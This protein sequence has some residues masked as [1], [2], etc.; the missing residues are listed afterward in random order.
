MKFK[1]MG[2]TL[3]L[4]GAF[5]FLGCS[6]GGGGDTPDP[7]SA[8]FDNPDGSVTEDNAE[9]L[10][11]DAIDSQAG[12]ESVGSAIGGFLRLNPRVNEEIAKRFGASAPKLD[13]DS[14][15]AQ[16][17]F[18]D[19]VSG[20]EN[21][22]T[23]DLGCIYDTNPDYFP[24]CTV[25]GTIK[26]EAEDENNGSVDINDLVYDCGEGLDFECDGGIAFSDD[27]TCYDLSCTLN[28]DDSSLNGCINE[29]AQV[30]LSGDGGNVVCLTLAP[31]EDCSQ[32][33]ADWEDADGPLTITCDVE[34]KTA[35]LCPDSALG[36]NSLTAGS[37]DIDR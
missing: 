16:S 8:D 22:G 29:E 24:G 28:N 14:I 9:D 7:S 31:N 3:A 25:D 5:A 1:L 27:V 33:S 15:R 26:Y 37:C 34:D 35:S 4:V 13:V 18:S 2:V 32:V 36:I 12:T 19:C 23:V 11:S 20:D 6:S 21:S 17:D 10:M 30:L